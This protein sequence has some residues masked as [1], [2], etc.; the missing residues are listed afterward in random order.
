MSA[1]PWP[2]AIGG[3]DISLNK[4]LSLGGTALVPLGGG[5]GML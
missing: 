1:A 2:N 5:T 4:E 3:I